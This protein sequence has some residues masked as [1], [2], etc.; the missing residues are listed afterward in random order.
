MASRA[1]EESR[2][3]WPGEEAASYTRGFA[4]TATRLRE[5]LM[6][7]MTV[8]GAECMRALCRGGFVVRPSPRGFV[9]LEQRGD[10][11]RIPL[12]E[13]IDR[14]A[15]AAI[16]HRAGLEPARFLELLYG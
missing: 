8:S 2:Y 7:P 11:V 6:L 16:L 12:I 5:W 4:D 13:E 1:L 9:D 15:L 14:Y 10:I 3:V